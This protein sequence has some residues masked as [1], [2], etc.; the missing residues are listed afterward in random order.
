MSLV[1]RREDPPSTSSRESRWDRASRSHD[2][3]WALLG[4][5]LLGPVGLILDPMARKR[6]GWSGLAVFSGL[7]WMAVALRGASLLHADTRPMVLAGV[8]GFLV[9]ASVLGGLAWFR[10]VWYGADMARRSRRWPPPLLGFPPLTFLAGLLAPGLG[11]A[12][13]HRPARAALTVFGVPA[14]AASLLV[15]SRSQVIWEAMAGASPTLRLGTELFSIAAGCVA[16]LGAVVWVAQAL[17]GAVLMAGREAPRPL[18]TELALGLLLSL[19]VLLGFMNP[20]QAAKNLDAV[21]EGF[22]IDGYSILP[23]ET[24]RLATILD[25]GQPLYALHLAD[26]YEAR[27]DVLAARSIRRELT[28]RWSVVASTN[29]PERRRPER[30]LT[31]YP[32]PADVFAPPAGH[33]PPERP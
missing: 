14:V 29:A 5:Y 6:L 26:R 2:G 30:V 28:N 19:V 8:L 27:G 23:V 33:L 12:L 16:V 25:P 31:A 3:G 21:A 10:G 20:H 13:A 15:L 18:G 32:D 22:Q 4:T 1:E 24:T 11:F 7:A 17:D 9:V